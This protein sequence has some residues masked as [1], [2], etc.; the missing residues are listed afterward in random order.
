MYYDFLINVIVVLFLC[1]VVIWLDLSIHRKYSHYILGVMFGLITIFV[2][3]SKI[4]VVEGRFYDFR[5]II[6]TMAGFIGGPVTALIA[7]IISSLYRY[8]VG[9]SGAMSG[10]TVIIVFGCFGSI[11]GRRVKSSQIGKKLL[12][13]F[14]IGIVMAFVLIF[15]IA[16]APPWK[17]ESGEV[18]RIVAGPFLLFTPLATTIIFNFYY[19]AYEF[20]G[21]ASMLN[22]IVN[23]SP[24]NLMIFDTK[25]PILLSNNMKKQRQFSPY[26]EN[27][28]LL[29]SSDKTWL[30][31]TK[32]QHREIDTEDGRHFV[33]DLSNFQMPSGECACVAI[34]NDVTDRKRE[35]D[36]L[37]GAMERFSKAFQLGPH[38]M[39]II[40]KSDHRYVDANRRFLEARGFA[41]EDV[42]GKT[43]TEIGVPESEFKQ[44]IETLEAQGSVQN[45]EG[46]IIEKYG[47]KGTVVLSA[48]KIQIDGQECVLFAYN[49]VTEIKRMQTERVEQLTKYLTL[50]ADLS[51]SNQLI[52]D[53]I[54]N[55]PDCFYVLDNQWRFT[56]VNNK[57]EVLLN[58]TREELL[59]KVFWETIPQ[60]RGTILELN[61]QKARN[62]CL[63]I[64]F[65]YLS[66]LYKD[67]WHQETVYPSQFGLS[68]YYRDITEQKLSRE[69]LIE[70]QKQKA[71]ILESMTESF[72]AID[73]DWQ[74]IYVNHAA[75]IASGKS[76]DELLGKKSTEVFRFND[77]AL[78][79]YQEVMNEKR[80]V[81]FEIISEALGNKWLE[82]SAYPT[83]TGMTCFF[84]DITSRKI[85]EQEFARLDRLSLVGQLA[86]GIGHELRNPMTT[87]RGYLQ[88]LGAKPGNAA[89]K[90]TFDLM[91]SELDRA[92]SII[93]EFLSLAQLKQTELKSQNLN[94]ILNNLY[95]LLESDTFTQNKQISFIPG[96]IPNL[97][98][99]AKEIIQLVLNLTRNGLEA[100]WERGC[101]TVKS[102]LQDGKVILA[103]ADEG[104]GIPPE[105]ISKV[106]T[107]FFT[108][109]DN[110]TGLGLAT[111]YKIAESHNAKIQI[112]SST[113]GTTFLIFFPIPDEDEDQN[114]MTA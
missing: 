101:L 47:S 75:E 103:I 29:V 30:N 59:G 50:E 16:I 65:E 44:I 79:H 60:T 86:A 53:I 73:R 8:N 15:I 10:I 64:T 84:R 43:P 77:T 6:M 32:Q 52:A 83:E 40:R 45:I 2:M 55:M 67:T 74:F 70:S 112:D 9:G 88:L 63:P 27:S 21:K 66:F 68:V 89:Q 71:S 26:I 106:G 18:L 102:Y 13:W 97:K 7:A 78:L 57:T 98:L 19:W 109:K 35:Q 108:T 3:T 92:N 80:S 76:R 20:L 25:G 37:R 34:V 14:I 49:D 4:I 24:I 113:R 61:Y 91:I 33:A 96:E 1:S 62:D 90:S 41:R 23:F 100:M 46:S 48:E 114:E 31:T 94:D 17:N 42:I 85:S 38:M 105:N 107:P 69:K 51:R 111:C 82:I 22:T 58:K 12:F 36:V 81:T 87:V 28:T 5:H 99:N 72:F 56:F 110:G 93:T 95:P 54:N 104:C 11:L 39:T